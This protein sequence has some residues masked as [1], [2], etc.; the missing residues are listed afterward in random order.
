MKNR[1][2]IIREL[3]SLKSTPGSLRPEALWVVET[4]ERV[5]R[6]AHQ[7][8]NWQGND[9]RTERT[10]RSRGLALFVPANVLKVARSGLIV[11]LVIGVAIEGWI[12]TVSASSS[13]LPGEVLYHVKL[14]NESGELLAA[15]V[16]GSDHTVKTLLKHAGVRAEEY[17]LSKSSQQATAAIHSLKKTIASANVSF[18]EVEQDPSIDATAVAQVIDEKTE[19]LLHSLSEQVTT[20]AETVATDASSTSGAL[21]AT[22]SQVTALNKEVEE[23]RDLIEVTGAK[24]VE[25]I[26]EH[27][28]SGNESV[29]ISDVKQNVEQKLGRLVIDFATINADAEAAGTVSGTLPAVI[30]MVATG[31]LPVVTTTS[32]T[33][34]VTSV[35]STSSVTSITTASSTVGESTLPQ[36]KQQQVAAT[37]EKV[38]EA[39]KIV[40]NTVAEAKTLIA[41]NNIT[42]LLGAIKKV[43]ELTGVKK[44]TKNVLSQA[45]QASG[46]GSTVSNTV[47]TPDMNSST[48]LNLLPLIVNASGTFSTFSTSVVGMM[49]TGTGP[50]QPIKTPV[51]K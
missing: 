42:S 33:T 6:S 25:V 11:L 1:S 21:D 27:K 50:N 14:A 45:L 39:N 12:A 2:D 38:Q 18:R 24:A 19:A 44:E 17:H 20:S 7:S 13:S 5:L 9:G 35:V 28:I 16:L 30:G 34:G 31:T 4:R 47:V 32:I 22:N 49:A 41:T 40:A 10:F 8:K 23:T 29:D 26:I 43:Q 46:A 37:T 51:T 36:T 15:S 48:S 3:K